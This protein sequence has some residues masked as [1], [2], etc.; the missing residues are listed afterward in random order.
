[1]SHLPLPSESAHRLEVLED[2]QQIVSGALEAFKGRIAV[3]SSFGTEAAVLL[4]MVATI[5]PSVPVLFLNTGKLFGETLRYRDALAGQLGLT[6]VRDIRPNASA[7]AERDPEG[8]LFTTDPDACC[9]LRKVEPLRDVMRPFE[10]LLTGRKRVH[11]GLREDLPV[12]EV[13]DDHVKI[14]PLASMTGEDVATYL[15]VHDMVKHPLVADGYLSVGCYTCTTPTAPGEGVRSGRW[16]GQEKTECG[17]HL[18]PL[19]TT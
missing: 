13:T 18:A 12:V 6:D 7:V 5:D 3:M 2:P 17:I 8:L 14:N 10:A 4:H 1:M 19:R 16:R 15:A 9:A 11:G